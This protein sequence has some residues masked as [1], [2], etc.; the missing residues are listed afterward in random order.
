MTA[1]EKRCGWLLL[2][3][4]VLTGFVSALMGGF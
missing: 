4:L 2:A 1:A 3:L